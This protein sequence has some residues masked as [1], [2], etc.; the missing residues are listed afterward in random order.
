MS[1]RTFPLLNNLLRIKILNLLGQGRPAAV[2][3]YLD[4]QEGLV[5]MGKFLVPVALSLQGT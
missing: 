2:W 3:A 1:G 5:F 4:R